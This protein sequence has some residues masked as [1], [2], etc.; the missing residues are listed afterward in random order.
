MNRELFYQEQWNLMSIEEKKKILDELT[1]QDS[2][3]FF[4]VPKD[5]ID[6]KETGLFYQKE[7]KHQKYPFVF[8]PGVKKVLL[9]YEVSND[10]IPEGLKK[11][12]LEDLQGEKEYRDGCCEEIKE[13]I[14]RAR[15]E[16]NLKEAA[17]FEEDLECM[18][19]SER[20]YEGLIELIGMCVSPLRTVSIK[21]MIVE[22][23]MREIE[24]EKIGE[25]AIDG[26]LDDKL[27]KEAVQTAREL[28]PIYKAQNKENRFKNDYF[29]FL[30]L[31]TKKDTFLVE[32]IEPYKE[33]IEEEH[34]C[35]PTED[36][37]EYLC[38]CGARTFFWWGDEFDYT[39]VIEGEVE[40]NN[41]GL[42]IA[43]NPYCYE[44]VD[45][46]CITKGG[47]GGRACCGGDGEFNS[48]F[49]LST[50][51]RQEK[52]CIESTKQRFGRGF[53]YYRRIYHI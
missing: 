50:F 27:P 9:G 47:D 16:G 42:Y 13:E 17:E 20:S 36:E 5:R 11:C 7:D 51:Y 40:K 34:F 29:E 1:K 15:K 48:V 26:S 14:E 39:K 45:S 33:K 23:D 46:P 32:K 6:E 35:I 8:V 28:Y 31:S 41:F 44:L 18:M 2:F 37:W 4:F 12:I 30:K 21:P 10:K 25:W 53:F 38:G 19:E 22:Q 52:A 24:I 49:P 43:Y 3:P